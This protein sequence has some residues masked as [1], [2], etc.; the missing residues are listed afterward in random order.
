MKQ[1]FLYY[2]KDAQL[3]SNILSQNKTA[4]LCGCY[5]K[6]VASFP[7]RFMGSFNKFHS[8]RL[9][10]LSLIFLVYDS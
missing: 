8:S 2:D 5:F 1:L 7:S 10:S 9:K 4:F 6:D 3:T